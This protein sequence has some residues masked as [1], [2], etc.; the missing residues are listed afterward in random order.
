VPSILRDLARRT[1]N[2]IAARL[3]VYVTFHVR[4]KRA[5]DVRNW[6]DDPS[7]PAAR[8]AFVIQGPFW[9][10]DDFTLETVRL[11]RT[12]CPGAAVIVSTWEDEDPALVERARQ[13]GAE[14]ILNRKP[15]DGGL[16]NIKY[17]IT[18]AHAGLSRA[19]ALGYEHALK[20]RTDTRMYAPHIDRFFLAAIRRFPIFDSGDQRA[21]IFG[22]D[23]GTAKHRLYGISDMHIFGH[24]DDL[25]RY[26]S[27]DV[28]D[29]YDVT[30]SGDDVAV[31]ESYLAS[32]FLNAVGITPAW[33]QDDSDR[34]IATRFCILDHAMVDLF[35]TKYNVFRERRYVLYDTAEPQH[36]F[37]TFRDWLILHDRHQ[38]T[39]R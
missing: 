12:H 2:A 33:T 37:M 29:R 6:R 10:P 19:K 8:V 16:W 30:A 1:G 24:V 34:L 4:P 26:Y 31:P 32:R 25:L 21:R 35:W 39:P 28:D 13:A 11:Y 14:V 15:K 20:T 27:L 9:K 5:A 7:L 38:T 3:P 17:Q 22:F 18:S 23:L 36:A